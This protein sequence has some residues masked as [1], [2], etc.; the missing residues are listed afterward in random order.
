MSPQEREY[1][2]AA[3]SKYLSGGLEKWEAEKILRGLKLN[4]YDNLDPYE[5]EKIKQ[6]I[7]S[8]F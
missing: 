4:F 6:K 1:V 3:F 7:L 5:V 2:M 8:A